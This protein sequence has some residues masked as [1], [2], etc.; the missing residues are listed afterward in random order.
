MS[1]VFS[2]K[3]FL[4]YSSTI[5]VVQLFSITVVATS[6]LVFLRGP[7]NSFKFKLNRAKLTANR[8]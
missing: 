5:N 7:E 2:V 6:K 4:F 8:L 3:S 1:S